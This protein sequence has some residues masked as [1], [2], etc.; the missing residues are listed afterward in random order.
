M[1]VCD[2]DEAHECIPMRC[3]ENLKVPMQCFAVQCNKLSNLCR[4]SIERVVLVVEYVTFLVGG[5]RW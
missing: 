4:W 2:G 3:E 1:V 5:S